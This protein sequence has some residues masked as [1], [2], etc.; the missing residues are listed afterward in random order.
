M[1]DQ[2][3]KQQLLA[4]VDR[5]IEAV[6]DPRYAARKAMWTRHQHLEKVEKVPLQVTLPL[7]GGYS[8]VVQETIP[9]ETLLY[10]EGFARNIELQLRQKLFK[11]EHVPDDAVILP[12]LHIS[13]AYRT[14]ADEMWGV[15]LTTREA[16]YNHAAGGAYKPVP[17]IE[18]EADIDRLSYAST[19]VDLE[20]TRQRLEEARELVDD[21]LPVIVGANRLSTNPF[22]VVVR[23]RGMDNL[24]FDFVD[25]PQLVHRLMEFVTEGHV[26]Y[27]QALDGLGLIDTPVTW[28]GCRV[29]YEAGDAALERGSS[30]LAPS[31]AYIS[32][33]SAASISPAMFEEFLQPYHDRLARLFQPGRVYFHGCEDLT[34]KFRV[35]RHMPNLRRFHVSPWSNFASLAAEI[36][37]D[38]VMEKHV[39]PTNNLLLFTEEQMRAELVE[40][41]EVGGDLIMDLNLSDIHTVGG[42][43]ERL[44]MWA[45][46]AQEVTEQYAR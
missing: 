45:R 38:F 33:Q 43:P 2:E 46:V 27:L 42:R 12:I 35:M 26:R 5:L 1:T 11:H 24:L 3:R 8:G 30:G 18:S 10:P 39:H 34:H 15:R 40:A 23:L 6:A 20:T 37:R 29:Q 32:A 28:I 16:E 25:R 4:L 31:W 9:P 22:E 19:D 7:T 13:A 36:G 21:R 14:P 17:V 44:T 41:L